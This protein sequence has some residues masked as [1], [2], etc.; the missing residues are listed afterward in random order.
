[1]KTFTCTPA[2]SGWICIALTMASTPPAATIAEQLGGLLKAIEPRAAHPCSATVGCLAWVVMAATM[3]PKPPASTMEVLTSSFPAMA[4]RR[5]QTCLEIFYNKEYELEHKINV[6]KIFHQG[7]PF[8]LFFCP[9]I[10]T[11]PSW[12]VHS[13]LQEGGCQ[14]PIVFSS[15]LYTQT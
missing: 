6:A 3:S 13:E 2:T 8:F 11:S 9:F 12:A 1:M 5:V 10:K 15:T 7:L 4:L 14:D